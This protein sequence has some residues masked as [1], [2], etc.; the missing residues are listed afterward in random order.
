MAIGFRYPGQ[1]PVIDAVRVAL[2]KNTEAPMTAREVYSEAMKLRTGLRFNAVRVSLVKLLKRGEAVR[3][4]EG[5]HTRWL[6]PQRE[7][8]E[9]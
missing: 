6:A 8:T 2:E 4:G 9:P 3:L 7:T 5:I 1:M